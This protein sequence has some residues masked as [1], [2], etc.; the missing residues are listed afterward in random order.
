V[1]EWALLQPSLHAYE[2]IRAG[3]F[4]NLI[5]THGDP[6]YTSLVLAVLTFV[7]LLLMR[8]SRKYIVAE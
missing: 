3:M 6:V 1:R 5:K 7:G 4:G 8:D 2:M